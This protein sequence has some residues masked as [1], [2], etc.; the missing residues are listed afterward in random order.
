[1]V[2]LIFRLYFYKNSIFKTALSFP[3]NNTLNDIIIHFPLSFNSIG[4]ISKYIIPFLYIIRFF[5]IMIKGYK[6]SFCLCGNFNNLIT[7]N[8]IWFFIALLSIIISI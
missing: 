5:K 2:Q 6:F 7:I 1:M 8:N 4:L 3:N